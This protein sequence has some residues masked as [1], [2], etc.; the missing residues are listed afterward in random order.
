M[1]D[2]AAR[3]ALSDALLARARADRA[4][5]GATPSFVADEYADVALRALGRAG[6]L[7]PEG[8]EWRHCSPPLLAAGVACHASPR[9]RCACPGAGLQRAGH[10]HLVDSAW[11]GERPWLIR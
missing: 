8:T 11:A 10:D 4:R 3:V 2:D 1:T 6:A 5:Y 9:R 7:L